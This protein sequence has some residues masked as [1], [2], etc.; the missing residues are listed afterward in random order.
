MRN[1]ESSI[2]QLPELHYHIPGPLYPISVTRTSRD[3]PGSCFSVVMAEIR[4]RGHPIQI[5]AGHPM[6]LPWAKV[7]A[8]PVADY[9]V[10]SVT[11][12]SMGAA[13]KRGVHRATRAK[14]LRQCLPL[15]LRLKPSF[16]LLSPAVHSHRIFNYNNLAPLYPIDVTKTSRDSALLQPFAA[17]GYLVKGR[18]PTRSLLKMCDQR[19]AANLT[20]GT[21]MICLC[22]CAK[23]SGGVS[24]LL[25]IACRLRR[26]HLLPQEFNQVVQTRKTPALTGE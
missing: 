5:K 12:N 9:L 15:R 16:V 19:V 11:S 26:T 3:S 25:V 24:P 18:P 2:T 14:G 8:L 1:R 21:Q 10:S 17:P 4:L 13:R 7:L 20:S 23:P 6:R 22:R